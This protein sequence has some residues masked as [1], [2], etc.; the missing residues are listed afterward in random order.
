MVIKNTMSDPKDTECSDECLNMIKSNGEKENFI[1]VV[2]PKESLTSN[3]SMVH[4]LPGLNLNIIN[5][6]V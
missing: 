2:I 3:T 6:I 4:T 5:R 1:P